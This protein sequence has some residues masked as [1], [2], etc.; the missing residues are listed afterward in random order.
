M[1]LA[2]PLWLWG[3]LTLPVFFALYRRRERR[4]TLVMAELLD[5]RLRSETAAS[6]SAER[7]R[8]LALSMA[9]FFWH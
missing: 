8:P 3:L 9:L 4:L 5:P 6:T 2:H 1:N 7:L